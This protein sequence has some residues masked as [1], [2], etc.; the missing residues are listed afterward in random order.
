MFILLLTLSF[1]VADRIGVCDFSHVCEIKFC[2]SPRK[3]KR[4]WNFL[5]KLCIILET[6]YRTETMNIIFQIY[7]G[8]SV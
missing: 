1:S 4:A 3:K 2:L 8:L 6:I 5:G 7:P